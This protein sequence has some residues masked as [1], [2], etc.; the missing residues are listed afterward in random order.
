MYN[1]GYKPQQAAAKSASPRDPPLPEMANV[2]SAP[3]IP[4]QT[5]EKPNENIPIEAEY[6]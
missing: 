5:K 1:N 3:A 6:Y 4:P 2:A